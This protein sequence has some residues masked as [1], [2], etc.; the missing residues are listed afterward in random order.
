M[1]RPPPAGDP[2]LAGRIR[3]EEWLWAS[4]PM[5]DEEDEDDEEAFRGNSLPVLAIDENDGGD[6]DDDDDEG[7]EEQEDEEDGLEPEGAPP[8]SRAAC[9]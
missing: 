2:A 8:G 9:P 5:A 6:E 3:L 4:Y 7:A 1:R